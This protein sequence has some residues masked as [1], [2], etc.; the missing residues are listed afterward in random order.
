CAAEPFH[1][2]QILLLP[3]W[4]A[5]CRHAGGMVGPGSVSRLLPGQH[6]GGGLRLAQP[7]AW[8]WGPGGRAFGHNLDSHHAGWPS[9]LAYLARAV[10]DCDLPGTHLGCSIPGAHTPE[11]G[12]GD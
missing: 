2:P 1:A 7:R 9:G 4:L 11:A 6:A 5:R 10:S 3:S 12:W 8:G